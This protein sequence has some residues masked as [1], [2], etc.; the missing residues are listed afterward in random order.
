MATA[1]G[2]ALMA[3]GAVIDTIDMSLA[4]I[5]SFLIVIILIEIGSPYTW[6]VWITTSLVTFL[7]FP[8]STVWVMYFVFGAFPILKHYIER[9][10]RIYWLILKLLYV[11]ASIVG[12]MFFIEAF[13]GLPL[14]DTE[15]QILRL[16]LYVILNIAFLA[17]DRILTLVAR[18]YIYKYRQR[19]RHLFK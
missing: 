12:L 17:Y 8:S 5:A 16:V 1:L 2:A 18:I 4:A 14:F 10:R 19:F 13:F 15:N 6:L 7:L 3:L 11:N 9:L